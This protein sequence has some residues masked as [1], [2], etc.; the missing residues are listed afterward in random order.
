MIRATAAL[1]L[2]FASSLSL[3][4]TPAGKPVARAA[5]AAAAADLLES[6]ASW[7]EKVTVTIAGNGEARSCRWE[8]SLQ[9]NNA[10]D[11][12][13][14]GAKARTA[15]GISG[16]GQLTRITFE[17]RF[18]PGARPAADQLAVGDTL[19]GR[20]DL[21]LAIDGRGQ[22]KAC[23]IVST[24]GS[25]TPDYGCDEA[26]AERFQASMSGAKPSAQREATMTILV[27]GHAEHLV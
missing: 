9:P 17:R 11:C 5:S 6:S 25:L 21:A 14:V 13:V 7:W 20:Q 12:D 19:L 8:S 2:L 27:Y 26:Q 23:R 15:K 3:A 18:S 10:Q 4:A 1:V 24:A 16:D 22:V